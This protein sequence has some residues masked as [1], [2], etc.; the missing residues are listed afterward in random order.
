M[1]QVCGD[2]S[3]DYLWD[4][5]HNVALGLTRKVAD[6]WAS[7][8]PNSPTVDAM[9]AVL[10]RVYLSEWS[11]Y[12]GIRWETRDLEA[13]L[14]S[15]NSSRNEII[16]LRSNTNPEILSDV[17]ISIEKELCEARTKWAL[18]D[19]ESPPTVIVI[20][21]IEHILFTHRLTRRPC[22]PKLPNT[23]LK[24]ENQ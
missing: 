12:S 9:I 17:Q 11:E 1:A 23:V 14:N 15:V 6:S 13:W 5:M 3:F 18:G 7:V 19:P 21:A 2:S 20:N 4:R 10:Y 8:A 22:D 24:M 16:I